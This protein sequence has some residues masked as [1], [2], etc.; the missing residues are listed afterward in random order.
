MFAGQSVS[1]VTSFY[2][3][4]GDQGFASQLVRQFPNITL[5]DV[6]EILTELISVVERLAQAVEALFVLSLVAGLLVLW[7]ALSATRDERLFDA[8][9]LRTLGASRRQVRTVVLAE[10]IWLGA[11]TGLLAGA[12]AMALGALAASKLFNLPFSLNPSLLP[13]GMALG[14]LLVPLAGWPLV[15]RVLRQAPAQLL[16]AL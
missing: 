16:R 7:A 11:L 3:A 8:A 9:L 12:G 1:L 10:L 2:L 15:R 13:L 6:S 14:M 5:I 4:P